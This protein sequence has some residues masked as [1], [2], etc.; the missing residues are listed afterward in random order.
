MGSAGDP[1]CDMSRYTKTVNFIDMIL[2]IHE[3]VY[4][5]YF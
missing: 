1:I 5:R 4:M 2:V 3:I